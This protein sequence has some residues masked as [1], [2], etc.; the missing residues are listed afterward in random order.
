M[1]FLSMGLVY[2]APVPAFTERLGAL[3]KLGYVWNWTVKYET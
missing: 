2:T 1:A 3:A